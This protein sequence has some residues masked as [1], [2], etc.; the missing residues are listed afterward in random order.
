MSGI[1]FVDKTVVYNGQPQ[2]IL[3][4]GDLPAG[5]EVSYINNGN[6]VVGQYT[7]TA[8]FVG[9]VNYNV[10]DDMT[11]VLTINK[12]THDMSGISFVDTS[13]IYNGQVQSVVITGT[14]PSGVSVSYTGNSG[15]NVGT[16][17][18]VATFVYDTVNYNAIADMSATLTIGKA[19]FDMSG[20]SFDDKSV[21]YNGQ[22]QTVV[23]TGTLPSGVTVSYPG[24]SGTT[25]GTYNAVATF[26]YDTVN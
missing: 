19:T 7:I 15:T 20:I 12:A 8:Q 11:A 2:S 5:V 9:N 26:S 17:N 18:A 1:T 10:I 3:I 14:L 25:V 6:T 21:I 24:N 23:I 4:G 16:Y 13:V 22:V